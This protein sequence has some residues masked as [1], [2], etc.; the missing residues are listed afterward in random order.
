M[1][2]LPDFAAF[3]KLAKDA[4]IDMIQMRNL[5]IDP[6]LLVRNSFSV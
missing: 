2:R 3:L 6:Q 1:A 5:N 4:K